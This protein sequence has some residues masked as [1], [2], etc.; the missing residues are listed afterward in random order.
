MEFTLFQ[1]LYCSTISEPTISVIQNNREE[2]ER[3]T[4]PHTPLLRLLPL[5]MLVIV[6]ILLP[7][8]LEGEMGGLLV[9]VVAAAAVERLLRS[10]GIVQDIIGMDAVSSGGLDGLLQDK[11]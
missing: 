10:N 9:V 8:L 7:L 1:A 4:L 5:L 6:M 11:Y 3:K 2:V